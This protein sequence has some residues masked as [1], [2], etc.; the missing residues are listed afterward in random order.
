MN[1]AIEARFLGFA[2]GPDPLGFALGPDPLGFALVFVFLSNSKAAVYWGFVEAPMA[3]WIR[4]SSCRCQMTVFTVVSHNVM[5]SGIT[6]RFFVVPHDFAELF[7]K[8]G[9]PTNRKAGVI[10]DG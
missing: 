9:V 8:L 7:T 4:A 1:S 6:Y 2:L 5:R 10:P 3:S